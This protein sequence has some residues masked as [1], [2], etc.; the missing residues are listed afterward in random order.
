MNTKDNLKIV[1]QQI[2]KYYSNMSKI[3]KLKRKLEILEKQKNDIENDIETSNIHLSS[4]IISIPYNNIKTSTT[5]FSS[6]QEKNLEKAFKKLENQLV[7]INFEISYLKVEIRDIERES[8]IIEMILEELDEESK[9]IIIF[10]Y[11]KKYTL[12]KTANELKFDEST[13]RR[14]R[15]K[16]MESIANMKI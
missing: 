3:E 1:E 4:D 15:N 9:N 6:L 10:L 11:K 2:K 13:I 8:S 7:E 5:F 14:K 12:I 16:I